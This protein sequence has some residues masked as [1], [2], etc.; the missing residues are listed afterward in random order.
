M[1]TFL[2]STEQTLLG[3][4]L[5]LNVLCLFA[6]EGNNFIFSIL[7]EQWG[8]YN[9][10][11]MKLQ[12]GVTDKLAKFEGGREYNEVY[13]VVYRGKLTDG[14]PVPVNNIAYKSAM[15]MLYHYVTSKQSLTTDLTSYTEENERIKLSNEQLR[16]PFFTLVFGL[17][18]FLLAIIYGWCDAG[19]CQYIRVAVWIVT[20]LSVVYW[21]A[22]WSCF[23][24]RNM[25]GEDADNAGES[26]IWYKV[27]E[28]CGWFWGAVIKIAGCAALAS[29]LLWA[30][31]FYVMPSAIGFVW[32]TASLM[33]VIVAIG[34]S[35]V[36]KCKIKGNS[37]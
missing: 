3:V 21:I 29:F 7:M 2:T 28:K 4:I 9:G 31:D 37:R 32:V 36:V 5:T 30:V 17:A 18:V 11:L 26:S 16:A 14:T 13:E 15:Q 6:I 23:M 20:A 10:S 8:K 25:T 27:D 22:L 12:K 19:S 24:F 35:R 33:L 1:C 34:I